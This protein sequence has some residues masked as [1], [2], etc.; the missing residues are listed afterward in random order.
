MQVTIRKWLM[1]KLLH[2]FIIRQKPILYL[3]NVNLINTLKRPTVQPFHII[4][5]K[6]SISFLSTFSSI[7]T[8]KIILCTRT[9]IFVFSSLLAQCS[10]YFAKL[11][12]VGIPSKGNQRIFCVLRTSKI[13]NFCVGFM[14]CSSYVAQQQAIA[15][16]REHH[17][18]IWPETGLG[19]SWELPV[20]LRHLN[21][22]YRIGQRISSA[23]SLGWCLSRI[24]PKPPCSTGAIRL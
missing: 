7:R 24:H 8:A 10:Y 2:S 11:I 17:K 4:P 1:G 14:I 18:G 5:T 16:C 12:N 13:N 15:G 9:G 6:F 19:L 23:K 21:K 20:S 22:L 3:N